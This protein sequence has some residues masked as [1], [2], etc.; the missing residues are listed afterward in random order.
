MGH[1]V[2]TST[3]FHLQHFLEAIL[4]DH[5]GSGHFAG[6]EPDSSSEDGEVREQ[7]NDQDSVITEP[8]VSEG[9]QESLVSTLVATRRLIR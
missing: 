8:S 7:F 2:H 1:W 6:L 5:E 4:Q 3:V 9:N